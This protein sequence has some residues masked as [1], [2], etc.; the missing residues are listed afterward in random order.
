MYCTS[1]GPQVPCRFRWYL[2]FRQVA[3]AGSRAGANPPP[4]SELGNRRPHLEQFF[5]RAFG[6][7]CESDSQSTTQ[8]AGAIE[9]LALPSNSTSKPLFCLNTHCFLFL[10]SSS[11]KTA[12]IG[13]WAVDRDALEFEKATFLPLVSASA[14][15]K[16]LVQGALLPKKDPIS[17]P[18]II[19]VSF[20]LGQGSQPPPR[21]GLVGYHDH[22]PCR[23]V[24]RISSC[25]SR[26]A[27]AAPPRL[28]DFWPCKILHLA[29]HCYSI[30]GP[31]AAVLQRP[32]ARRHPRSRFKPR[33]HEAMANSAS[34]PDS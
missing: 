8:L 32:Q 26:L 5:F 7:K 16:T 29:R 2:S 30:A 25:N 9:V 34:G 19:T 13:P 3:G 31:L 4:A 12:Q 6:C 22:G 33:R 10:A 27:A 15:A 28:G 21:A 14:A 24:S 11:S 17:P 23:L 1:P 20:I 18:G